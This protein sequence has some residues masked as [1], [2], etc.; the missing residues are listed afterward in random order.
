MTIPQ[1]ESLSYMQTD[2]H[3]LLLICINNV[4]VNNEDCTFER[5][6]YECFTN[7][8]KAFCLFR[9]PQWPDSNKLDRPLRK[10][11]ERGLIVGSPKIGFLLTEDGKHQVGR[12]K[13]MLE[14]QVKLKPTPRV[15]KGKERNFVAYIKTGELYQRFIR[16]KYNFDLTE[17]EFIGFL[18]ATLETPKRVLRQNL[19]QYE[20]LAE[21]FGDIDLQEFL[22]TC[23]LKMKPLLD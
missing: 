7:F 6:V 2:L 19:A 3:S 18:R 14:Q 13:K 16:D 21:N 8:P 22:R 4:V 11:R 20:K 5:L 9:Y 23:K 1:Y 12:A 15:L 17:Q 10:L